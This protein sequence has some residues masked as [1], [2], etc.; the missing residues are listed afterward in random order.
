MNIG[1][2][3]TKTLQIIR[4][5]SNS[6][7]LIS[8]SDNADYLL[9]MNTFINEAQ[10]E[11]NTKRPIVKKITLSNPVSTDYF[12]KYDMPNN[13]IGLKELKLNDYAFDDYAWEDKTLVIPNSYDGILLLLYYAEPTLIDND[14]IDDADL[15][16]DTDL[17]LIIPYYVAGHVFVEDNFDLSQFFLNEYT[18]KLKRVKSKN[19]QTRV[20]RNRR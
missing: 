18:L 19:A 1:E 14:T 15:E 17:Q 11:L 8:A 20:G 9:S 4:Q 6:G 10:F 7:T 16:I 5:Y 3:K 2:I 13:F 12:S